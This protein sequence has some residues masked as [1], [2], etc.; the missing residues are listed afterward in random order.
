MLYTYLCNYG[1][2][3]FLYCCILP[4]PVADLVYWR[5]MWWTGVVF[6][7]LVIGLASLFQLSTITVLCNVFLGVMCLTFPLRLYY[8][9]LEVLRWNP[10]VHP[11]QWVCWFR[12]EPKLSVLTLVHSWVCFHGAAVGFLTPGSNADLDTNRLGYQLI[13]M[14]TNTNK[15]QIG[16]TCQ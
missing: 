7:G 9:L 1:L 4:L 11:F 2:V 5:N 14:S 3:I 13:N 10:G 16:S 8:K 15:S 12:H 6:T